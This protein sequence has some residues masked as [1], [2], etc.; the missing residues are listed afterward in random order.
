[1]DREEREIKSNLKKIII[2]NLIKQT[3]Q[4]GNNQNLFFLKG[5]YR[6][7]RNYRVNAD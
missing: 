7:K 4:E 1:M 5:N 2:K 3:E 6:V